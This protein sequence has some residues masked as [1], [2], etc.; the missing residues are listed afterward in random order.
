MTGLA[1]DTTA[2]R[3]QFEL[4]ADLVQPL[5]DGCEAGS[6]QRVEV[7]PPQQPGREAVLYLP[8]A[9]D[10]ENTVFMVRSLAHRRPIV[11]GYSGQRPAFFASI[12]DAFADPSSIDARPL[13][14]SSD[15]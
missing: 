9:I 1:G 13:Q 10:K 6:A 7:V 14:P 4:S 2:G 3:A 12:V 15:Q 8:L 11:N 5:A